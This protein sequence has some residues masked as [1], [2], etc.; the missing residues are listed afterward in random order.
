MDLQ[1]AKKLNLSVKFVPFVFIRDKFGVAG[2]GIMLLMNDQMLIDI[3]VVVFANFFNLAIAVIMLSRVKQWGR[4]EY[5]LGL[6]TSL[7][8]IPV[9]WALFS[10]MHAGR[11]SWMVILPG[12]V[13][14]FLVIEFLLDYVLKSDFRHTRW[15]GAY[16][17]VFYLAQ[18]AMIGYGFLAD[19]TYGF[20]TL[21][22]YFISL[23]ATGYSYKKVGHGIPGESA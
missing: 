20:V 22:T 12:V 14:L 13:M 21:I 4:L 23:A 19:S 2:K 9:G 11:S 18:W 7:G 3:S 17:L 15:V 1:I 5:V 10:N 6:L 16:L 8:V